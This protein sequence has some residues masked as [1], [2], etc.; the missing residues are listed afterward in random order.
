MLVNE[1]VG[2]AEGPTE[3]PPSL[4][5]SSHTSVRY[6]RKT[7]RAV[8]RPASG[9]SLIELMVVAGIVVVLFACALPLTKGIFYMYRL[10][11]AA[12]TAAMAIQSTRYH[13]IM[14][15][16]PYQI[17]LSATTNSY[18]VLSEVP[19][20]ITFSNVGAAIPV[21]PGG[22]ST[23]GATTT[24]QFSPGGIVTL[25]GGNMPAAFTIT[26]PSGTKTLTVSSVGNVTITP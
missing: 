6:S 24:F 23:I 7:G 14:Q 8:A 17:K 18:Q 9:F 4:A 11:A 19:P 13:A 21:D 1:S 22:T 3:A 15:S 25:V 5:C 20:A 12:T 10:R 2:L 16:Y 26:N